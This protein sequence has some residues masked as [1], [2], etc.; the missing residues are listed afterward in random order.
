MIR[1]CA[2]WAILVL[3]M[4]GSLTAQDTLF[5][6]TQKTV[7]LAFGGKI[8]L[9]DVGSTQ[10]IAQIEKE[11]LLLKAVM[12]YPEPTSL[13][14]RYLSQGK[15]QYYHAV[16]IYRPFIS[17]HFFDL[18]GQVAQPTTQP[19]Q[20]PSQQTYLVNQTFT[21][22]QAHPQAYAKGSQSHFSQ[23]SA[24][25][26]MLRSSDQEIKNIVS[27]VGKVETR[28]EMIRTDQQHLYL[29]LSITNRSSLPFEIG[30]LGY[31][32]LRKGQKGISELIPEEIIL[33]QTVP[34]YERVSGIVMVPVLTPNRGDKL[35][36]RI[37]EATNRQT[38]LQIPATYLLNAKLF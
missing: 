2:S 33:P 12:E 6:N 10:F 27:V 37:R 22:S 14:V 21:G 18:R 35:V 36:I 30:A 4:I 7:T 1:I 20:P 15:T 13:V 32:L 34:A 9:I 11:L 38:H 17:Q 3:G 29:K 23:S 5:V 8:D 26:E 24:V 25:E 16:L 31:D 28:L 19:V